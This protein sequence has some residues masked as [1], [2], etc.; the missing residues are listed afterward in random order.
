M[1]IHQFVV[2]TTVLAGVYVAT[3][4]AQQPSRDLSNEEQAACRSDAIRLCFFKISNAE[5]LKACLRSNKPDLSPSCKKL[6]E[7]RGN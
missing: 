4:Q 3:A 5:A 6:I 1:R 7:S 2:C